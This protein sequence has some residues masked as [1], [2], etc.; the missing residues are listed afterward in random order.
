MDRLVVRYGLAS[1]VGFLA[2]NDGAGL[3]AAGG[4]DCGGSDDSILPGL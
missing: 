4:G 3:C 2:F 1:A